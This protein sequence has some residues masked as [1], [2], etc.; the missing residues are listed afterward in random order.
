VSHGA[1]LTLFGT[2][3]VVV[4]VGALFSAQAG[5]G[6]SLARLLLWFAF[7]P[8]VWMFAHGLRSLTRSLGAAYPTTRPPWNE[9]ADWH[10][11]GELMPDV[12]PLATW[13]AFTASCALAGYVVRPSLVFAVALGAALALVPAL[14][15]IRM[16]LHR[17]RVRDMRVFAMEPPVRVGQELRVQLRNPYPGAVPTKGQA[18]LRNIRE[19]ARAT[20][21]IV[22]TGDDAGAPGR[23]RARKRRWQ[24]RPRHLRELLAG[25]AVNL[26]PAFEERDDDIIAF[27]IGVPESGRETWLSTF[28][29]IYWELEVELRYERGGPTLSPSEKNRWLVPIYNEDVGSSDAETSTPA[30]SALR[31]KGMCPR[32]AVPLDEGDACG[33]CGGRMVPAPEVADFVTT[34][35]H[36]DLTMLREL[37]EQ[38]AGDAPDCPS[39]TRRMSPVTMK[40]QAVDLCL[41]C[42]SLW[43]DAG[44]LERARAAAEGAH[45][46]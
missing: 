30:G 17:A 24:T 38:F 23:P 28:S 2:L 20:D 4:S 6:F 37:A 27:S 18:S 42:G 15:V 34:R 29:P 31:V 12:P 13:I 36:L 45:D 19:M 33:S 21:D 40:G 7:T 11:T 44:E 35:L 10:A 26:A 43:V 32:C 25:A 1:S 39:C 46:H 9:D 3:L 16:V 22:V 8:G 14:I 5:S 41:G